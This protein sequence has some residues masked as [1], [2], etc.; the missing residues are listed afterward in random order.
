MRVSISSLFSGIYF[1]FV[2]INY[3][4]KYVLYPLVG[5]FFW[6]SKMQTKLHEG[7]EKKWMISCDFFCL[8]FDRSRGYGEE[9]NPVL[10]GIRHSDKKF[11]SRREPTSAQNCRH[12]ALENASTES[13]LVL[14]PHLIGWKVGPSFPGQ[15]QREAK[16]N[17][18]N[19]WLLFEPKSKGL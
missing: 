15:S 13:W 12:F 18:C 17:L 11:L 19:H 6:V 5:K 4:E 3:G 2:A 8:T 14:M 16:Q 10:T 1:E 7:R 9:K